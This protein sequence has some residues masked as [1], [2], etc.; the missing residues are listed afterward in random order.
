MERPLVLVYTDHPMCSI[1][2]ADATCE[3][4]SRS[5]VYDVKMIGPSSFPYL[6]FNKYNIERAK[7]IVFPGGEGDADQFDNSLTHY[8]DIIKNYVYNGGKYLGICQGSYFASKH[9]FNLL[10][11]YVAEQHIK[12]KRSSTKRR[13]P[14]IVSIEWNGIYNGTYPI[15]FHD[16]AAFIQTKETAE[17]D[18]LATYENGEAAALIQDHGKGT[19]AVI[20]PHPE[21]MKWWFYSQPKVKEGW[22]DSIQQWMLVEMMEDLMNS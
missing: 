19:V 9:F 21:A 12:R 6:D 3:V 1:D 5:G 10:D 4:L 15:Y 20:G 8:K 13:G 14:A 22:K 11:G 7:C 17:A 16:G 18:I 2:C